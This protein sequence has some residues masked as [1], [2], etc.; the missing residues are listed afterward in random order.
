MIGDLNGD[1]VPTA[2]AAPAAIVL[3]AGAGRRMGGR[4]KAL[5]LRDGETLLARQ[6]RMLRAAGV[7]RVVVVLGHHAPAIEAALRPL[8]AE[9][10]LP[11]GALGWVRNPAPDLGPGSSLRAGLAALPEGGDVLVALAD[12]P[13]LAPPDVVTLLQA[14]RGRRAG[15]ELLVPMHAGTPGHPVVF[16]PA[17]RA[18]VQ[19]LGGG[20]GVR[21]WRRAHPAQVQWLAVDH[22]RFTC[23]VDTPKAVLALAHRHGVALRWPGGV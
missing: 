18:A 11:Q 20:E 17:V 9:L 1:F 16:S 19:R 12:Q 7:P 15:C 2:P 13:L 21:E 8:V 6:L 22:A 10:G 23:D 3:A 4:P 5:L 14:W